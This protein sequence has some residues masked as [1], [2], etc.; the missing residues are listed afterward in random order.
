MKL[1]EYL[2]Q[3]ERGGPAQLAKTLGIS[4]S[5]LSQLASGAAP[6]SPARCVEIEH[7]TN[8]KVT[9]KDLRDDWASIWPELI[10]VRNRRSTDKSG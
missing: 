3:L 4:S 8:G 5:F 10:P 1:K 6:I 7:A 9:R 2:D